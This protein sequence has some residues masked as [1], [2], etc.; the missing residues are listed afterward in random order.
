MKGKTLFKL[1]IVAMSMLIN[2]TL[3]FRITNIG[4][5][6][7]AKVNPLDTVTPAPICVTPTPIS[8][9]DVTYHC[10]YVMAKQYVYV[11]FWEPSGYPVDANFNNLILR[12]YNDLGS[13]SNGLYNLLSQYPDDHGNIPS[14]TTLVASTVDSS[15]YP[16]YCPS[17]PTLM[18]CFL[19]NEDIRSEITTVINNENWGCSTGPYTCY[20]VLYTASHVQGEQDNDSLVDCGFHSS[21]GG[22]DDPIIYGYV[23]YGRTCVTDPTGNSPNNCIDCDDAIS[24][25]AHEQFEAATD[26]YHGQGWLGGGSNLPEIGDKCQFYGTPPLG[27]DNGLANQQ[28][29]NGSPTPTPDYYR[30][31]QMWDNNTSMCSLGTQTP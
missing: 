21:I 16:S 28:W 7:I 6:N 30:I 25:S 22:Y 15:S 9:S 1:L 3:L 4:A 8:G 27:Y 23:E 17:T 31:Q 12:Y 29:F 10:G 11:I 13:N 2:I 20:Y 24:T 5:S 26:P 14:F 18:E 19:E